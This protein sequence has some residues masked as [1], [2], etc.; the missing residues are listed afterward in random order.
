[1]VEVKKKDVENSHIII[2]SS[3]TDAPINKLEIVTVPDKPSG[4][5]WRF[6]ESPVKKWAKSK[7]IA[8]YDAPKDSPT[9]RNWTMPANTFD[10]G[11]VASF[12]YFLTPNVLE[13]FREGCINVHPSLL[14]NYR[15]A[16]PIQYALLNGDD[17]TGISIIDV[18]P[19]ELDV[20]SILFQ[21][22]I[23]IPYRSDFTSLSAILAR[24]SGRI[25][26]QIL[27]NY[28][29][30]RSHAISQEI[31]VKQGHIISYAPKIHRSSFPPI[32]LDRMT[33]YQ[34]DRRHRS[35][36]HQVPTS[37]TYENK[38]LRFLCIEPIQNS[39]YRIDTGTLVYVPTRKKLRIGCA[40][41]TILEI[42]SVFYQNKQLTAQEFANGYRINRDSDILSASNNEHTL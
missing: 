37:I 25:L 6:H 5:G 3:L 40:E 19:T 32:A 16:S 30:F 17:I 10:L 11:I 24:E 35:I 38:E 23:P 7:G 31:L 18:H 4:R 28:E 27:T 1:M 26:A 2:G 33:A 20:G 39:S 41:G 15:G 12:G 29:T 21:A 13:T 14:P 34:I 42:S 8:V 36:G 9:L 22:K